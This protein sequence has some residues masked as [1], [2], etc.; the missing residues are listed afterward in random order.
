MKKVFTNSSDVIHLFAQRTQDEARCSNVFFYGNTIYSYGYHYTLGQFI[1]DHTIVINDYGYSRTTQ[2]HISEIKYAT[3]QYKQF[4][5]TNTD[6]DHV[7]KQIKI[8]SKALVKAHK[9][10]KYI[11]DII[12]RWDK[13]NEFIKYRKDKNTPK[14][15]RYKETKKIVKNITDNLDAW[16]EKILQANKKEKQR[17]QKQVKELVNK[18]Y[19]YEINSFRKGDKDYL[20]ISLDGNNIE[21]NQYIKVSTE[22]ARKLYQLILNGVDIKGHRIS[23][24]TVTSINGTLKIGC[25]NI[26]MESVHKVGKQLI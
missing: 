13:L 1:D 14:D 24:Y 10:E 18:F 25:H 9:P 3:R 20:R 2:K 7:S 12:T 23:N 17:E 19:N 6:I 16:K 11:N 22:E 4:F 15:T 26:D 8:L 21:T 5:T